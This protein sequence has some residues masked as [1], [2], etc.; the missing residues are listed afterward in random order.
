MVR[1]V[2]GEKSRDRGSV[3]HLNIDQLL[4]RALTAQQANLA[5][6][7]LQYGRQQPEHRRVGSTVEGRRTN[8]DVERSVSE[9]TKRIETG[10]RVNVQRDTDHERQ[11]PP[12]C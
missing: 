12:E 8:V 10:T 5:W 3:V 6:P 1:S 2:Q 4:T 7:Q 9:H 11:T